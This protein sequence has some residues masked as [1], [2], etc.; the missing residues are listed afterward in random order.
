M[1]QFIIALSIITFSTSLKAAC[2]IEEVI[3]LYDSGYSATQV[4]EEC[5]GRVEESNCSL[6]KIIGY[7]QQE[8]GLASILRQC[9]IQENYSNQSYR[10]GQYQLPSATPARVCAT[11]YGSC[12]MAEPIPLGSSCYCPGSSGPVWGIGR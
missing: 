4:R 1:Q 12:P 7:S 11:P 10:R 3:D 9:E 8:M 2:F 6:G 5:D